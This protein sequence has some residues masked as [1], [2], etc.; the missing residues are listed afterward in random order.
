MNDYGHDLLFGSF[1]SPVRRP[2]RQAVDLAV[3]SERAGLDLVTFQD[4]P[5]HPGFHDTSTLLAYAAAKTR[6]IA[7]S[8]NVTSLPLRPPLGLARAAATVDR[9]S[10]GRFRLGVGAGAS[11]DGVEAMGG[12]R[13][14]A[15][16]SISALREAIGIIRDGW[17]ADR[18]E[19]LRH[20]GRFY[21]VVDGDRGPR[22]YHPIPIW[23]GAY[24]PRMLDLT[25]AVA[26]GWLPSLEYIEDGLRGITDGNARIDEAAVRA[27]REPSS[28]RRMM[29]FMRTGLGPAG[30]GF[31]DGPPEM[32]IDRLT[33]LALDHGISAFIIGGDDPGLIIR[34]GAEIAPAVRENV[35]QARGVRQH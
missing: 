19:P 17:D 18:P 24:K 16:Q 12:R 8:G 28:V 7:L 3:A 6:R 11:W 31:L 5:Y 30:Q 29:N 10:Q 22:P 14:G 35:A 23:V 25:G 9:L 32:W 21:R 13:L 15:G 26:D 27:G 33:A 4:H 20:E 2:A 34:F 1:P